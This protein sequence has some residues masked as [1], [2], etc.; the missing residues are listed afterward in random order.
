MANKIAWEYWNDKEKKLASKANEKTK[1]YDDDEEDH[2][3]FSS[4]HIKDIFMDTPSVI[5]SPFG[6]IPSDSQLKPSDRWECWLGYTDFEITQKIADK[7]SKVDGVEAMK[8]MGRYSFCIGVAKLFE[9]AKVRKDI[10]DTI[11]K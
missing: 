8:I 6:E 7:M 1:E 5:H 11:S 10:Y 3:P 2:N 4:S 9:F